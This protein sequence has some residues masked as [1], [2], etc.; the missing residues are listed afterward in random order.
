LTSAARSN[1]ARNGTT[2]N[3]AAATSVVV[4]YA[5]LTDPAAVNDLVSTV[6]S[7]GQ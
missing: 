5:D 2:S 3:T 7:T 4:R 6:T 1:L